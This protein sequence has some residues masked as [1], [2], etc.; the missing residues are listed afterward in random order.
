MPNATMQMRDTVYDS[1][2]EIIGTAD[3]HGYECCLHFHRTYS[4]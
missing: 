2:D 4:E 3:L 1:S